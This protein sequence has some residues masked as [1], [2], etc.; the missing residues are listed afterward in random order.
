MV[1]GERLYRRALDKSL[2][3]I[4]SFVSGDLVTVGETVSVAPDVLDKASYRSRSEGV[5]AV[6]PQFEVTLDRIELGANPLVLV[7]ESIE[8]PGN[9]GAML[10]TASAA[11]AD[12]MIAVGGAVDIFN[13]NVLRSSTG[14]VLSMPLAVTSWDELDQWLMNHGLT[15]VATSPDASTTLFETDISG[16]TAV[17]IGAEDIGLSEHAL[18]VASVTVTIP[19]VE[20]TTDSLNASVAAG[21]VLFEAVRQRGWGR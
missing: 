3:P 20:G 21:I 9:L 13:P 8:K 18:G 16:P 14:A 5:I 11:G 1:E 7:A 12:A 2:D 4:I 17:L 15:V 6:F 10:R 19:Q